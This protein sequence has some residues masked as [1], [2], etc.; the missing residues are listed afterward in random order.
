MINDYMRRQIEV[1]IGDLEDVEKCGCYRD[2]DGGF[3]QEHRGSIDHALLTL[4]LA[5]HGRV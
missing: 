1:A 5:L 2:D 4:R 3:D